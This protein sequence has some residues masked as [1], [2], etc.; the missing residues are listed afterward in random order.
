MR[1]RDYQS[2]AVDFLLQ[3]RRAFI[4]S[5]A[6]SGKTIMAASAA[7]RIAEPFWRIVWLANT[8]EQ[9]Q[10]ALAACGRFHWPEPVEIEVRCVAGRPDVTGADLVIIDESHHLPAATWWST[11][12]QAK[13]IV[14]GFSATPWSGDWERDTILKTFFGD[15]NFHT[16]CRKIVQAGGSITPG[17]VLIHDLD[18]SG[19]FD[20][21]IAAK[22]S[23]EVAKRIRRFPYIPKEEHER[24]ARWQFTAECVRT[25]QA[26]NAQI[27]KLA[28]GA[29]AVLV[30]VSTIEHGQHLT[31]RIAGAAL[32]HAKLGKKKRAAAIED[33][34]AGLLRCMVATSL[35]DEGLDVPR[36]STLILASGG[37]SA[38]KLEQR[39]G[40]VMRPHEGKEFG[41]VHDFAD[42]GAGLAH[43][44]FKA[45]LRTYKRL[46]YKIENSVEAVAA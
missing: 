18:V 12:A 28:N 2:Q 5:P 32:V 14:W 31:E 27:V 30:L 44:Q 38:G 20:D 19:M 25:N 15:E 42:R 8:R 34:R 39:A 16:V 35:A 6:G 10:Q 40:R 11:A 26:R 17:R 46:G 7:S 21:Y 36:A 13:A 4:V 45:R 33:F 23:E 29:S 22:T 43:S 9:V 37:R 24:R 41:L 1:L 3:R